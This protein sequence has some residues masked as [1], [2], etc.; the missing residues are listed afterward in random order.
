MLRDDT[1]NGCVAEQENADSGIYS[2]FGYTADRVVVKVNS[3]EKEK[4]NNNAQKQ[5][6]ITLAKERKKEK[7]KIKRKNKNIR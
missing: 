7:I 4:N 2:N 3:P 1:Q 5:E 6:P